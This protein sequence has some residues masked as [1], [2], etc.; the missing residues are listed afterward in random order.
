MSAN[1]AE[2][3]TTDVVTLTP[4]P[5]ALRRIEVCEDVEAQQPH[6]IWKSC[7]FNC[8]PTATVYFT[9]TIFSA[10]VLVWSLWMISI[11]SPCD[12]NLSWYT[13][14]VGLVAGQ[15]IESSSVLKQ[16]K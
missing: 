9:K 4:I 10:V 12:P 6:R 5:E 1:N 3:V 8:E 14:L 16:R 13:G 15:Q 7:C 2:A 11:A